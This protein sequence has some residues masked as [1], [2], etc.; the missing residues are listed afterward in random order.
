MLRCGL[1]CRCRT[2]SG[3]YPLRS[4]GAWAAQVGA[5]MTR[6]VGVCRPGHVG[7]K[8][9]EKT[10]GVHERS[11]RRRSAPRER[12]FRNTPNAALIAAAC[13]TTRRVANHMNS[14]PTGVAVHAET[15]PIG[16]TGCSSVLVCQSSNH[17]NINTRLT[18]HCSVYDLGM[19][20]NCEPVKRAA[21]G[22]ES[23]WT[24]GEARRSPG[25][26]GGLVVKCNR[27]SA[28]RMDPSPMCLSERLPRG[29]HLSCRGVGGNENANHLQH[30]DRTTRLHSDVPL[31]TFVFIHRVATVGPTNL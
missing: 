8:V 7:R 29:S 1:S 10:F 14:T 28:R 23:V 21:T 13:L 26:L 31:Y 3:R 12:G 5:E 22:T 18:T 30:P 16:F 6:L 27:S 15:Y 19:R 20:K 4:P 11:L 25:R 24:H 2:V 17:S 9:F